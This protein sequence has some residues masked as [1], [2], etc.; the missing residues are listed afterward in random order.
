MR[1]RPSTFSNLGTVHYWNGNFNAARQAYEQSLKLRP[2]AGI[3]RN[4]GDTLA[5]LHDAAGAQMQYLA[6]LDLAAAQLKVNPKDSASLSLSALVEAKL[7][8]SSDARAHIGAALAI[9]PLD[10][11]VRYR[12]ATIAALFGERD[13]ALA[14]LK[15]AIAVGYSALL[16]VRDLDLQSLRGLPEFAALVQANK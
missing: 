3:H 8:R 13:R 5:E 12:D 6:A 1:A 11:D 2:D 4:L 9:T 14:A 10:K 16:A 15:G 7:G